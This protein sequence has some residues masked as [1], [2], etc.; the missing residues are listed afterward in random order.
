M[1]CS[2]CGRLPGPICSLC[3]S[4]ERIRV[5]AA[6]EGCTAPTS[7]GSTLRV[8]RET[9]G[10]LSD[11]NEENS[12]W[13]LGPSGGV[14]PP[15]AGVEETP[16][17]AEPVY[18]G[19]AP[20]SKAAPPADKADRRDKKEKKDKERKRR[21]ERAAKARDPESPAALEPKASEKAEEEQPEEPHPPV[22]VGPHRVWGS[23]ARH[24][25]HRDHEEAGGSSANPGERRPREPSRSPQQSPVEEERK[26]HR[27]SKGAKHR[28][29]GR[30]WKEGHWS[31]ARSQQQWR[32]R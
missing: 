11:I 4:V 23:A 17:A 29:R 15:V 19:S 25:G 12:G 16:G 28:D 14:V 32:Q 3:R 27:G 6:S 2:K 1:L 18:E 7:W 21:K 10:I 30:Q 8:L 26:K 20:K 13:S 22:Q 9:C 5:L 31:G 24:F